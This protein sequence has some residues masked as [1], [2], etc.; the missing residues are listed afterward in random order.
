MLS[1]V[2]LL[3]AVAATPQS[4]RVSVYVSAPMRD[5]FFDTNKEIQGSV[6]DLRR[7]LSGMKK[8]VRLFDVREGADIVVTVVTRDVGSETY[9][10]RLSYTEYYNNAV[11]TSVSLWDNTLLGRRSNGGRDLSKGVHGGFYTRVQILHGRMGRVRNADRKGSQVLGSCQHEAN[12]TAAERH[13]TLT[14]VPA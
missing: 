12:K 11:L 3:A 2:L 7:K 6:K 5:G 9:G 14:P 1:L 8:L 4:A 10:E 13:Q